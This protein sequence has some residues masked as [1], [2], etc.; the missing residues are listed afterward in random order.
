MACK[1]GLP[2]FAFFTLLVTDGVTRAAFAIDRFMDFVNSRLANIPSEREVGLEIDAEHLAPRRVGGLGRRRASGLRE[3]AIVRFR[4]A[5]GR[6][7]PVPID[8]LRGPILS[9]VLGMAG[10]TTR[11]LHRV[12]LGV[13]GT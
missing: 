9:Q 10:R 13:R 5:T 12:V 2:G 6:C 8:Q 11:H 7:A 1:A 3:K 4:M